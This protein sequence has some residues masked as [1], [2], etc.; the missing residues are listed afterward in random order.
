MHSRLH[1]DGCFVPLHQNWALVVIVLNAVWIGID[2]DHN[3]PD[4]G[5]PLVVFDV[6]EH[7]FGFCFT[8]EILVRIF[9]YRNKMDFFNDKH[10]RF[11]NLFDLCL[12]V[13]MIIEI[14]VLPIVDADTSTLGSL[15]V[16]RLLR[17][18]RI[19]RVFRMVPELGM[20]VKSMAAAARS[21]SST[22]AIILALMYVFAIILTNWAKHS[23]ERLAKEVDG[24]P[25]FFDEMFGTIPKSMLT[26]WQVLVFDDTFSLI[27]ATLS[28]SFACGALLLVFILLGAFMIL[29][30]LIGVIC[31]IVSDTTE[32]EKDKL[33]RERIVEVFDAMDVD[34]S[35]TLTENEF[36]AQAAYRLQKLGVDED[37]VA[38]AFQIIDSSGHGCI[39]QDEFVQMLLKMLQPPTAQ[40]LLL[41]QKNLTMVQTLL[42]DYIKRTALRYQR[43]EAKID[44]LG[45]R[46]TSAEST[47]FGTDRL[48]STASLETVTR[49][50]VN[51][52][53][54]KK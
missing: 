16:L 51:Q 17:L 31:E 48:A 27:R 49:E 11:W 54:G 40:D 35:G 6:G 3:F 15:S 13:M 18:L 39:D 4:S 50:T 25:G 21:V 47:R 34:G 42:G 10:L 41:V 23:E 30:I 52:L 14:W 7:I 36:N 44:N 29:N 22:L 33:L 12:V 1:V 37:V 43:L 32:T 28:E 2:E 20:M 53:L 8:F 9:A 26:L 46:R 5:M 19:T 24:T 45:S 38:V